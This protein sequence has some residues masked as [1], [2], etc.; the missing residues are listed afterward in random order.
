[1]R[2]RRDDRRAATSPSVSG[3]PADAAPDRDGVAER[4]AE[5]VGVREQAEEEC[6]ERARAQDAH[7]DLPA[8]ARPEGPHCATQR[9]RREP[10]V[11]AAFGGGAG[12]RNEG[13]GEL[14]GDGRAERAS[15]RRRQDRD[16]TALRCAP[17]LLWRS[18]SGGGTGSFERAAA[19]VRQYASAS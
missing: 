7:A 19:R 15:R 2:A 12:A 18:G 3:R 5:R 14:A 16:A 8:P 17:L 13:R 1:D 4:G 9:D 11:S 6:A 10:L